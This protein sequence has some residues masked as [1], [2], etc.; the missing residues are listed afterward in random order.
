MAKTVNRVF[1]EF[2]LNTVNLDKDKT[3]S[4]RNNRD[5]LVAKIKD[6]PTSDNDFP[7]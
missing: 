6:L 4:A 2:M 3:I 1:N 7:L 5:W